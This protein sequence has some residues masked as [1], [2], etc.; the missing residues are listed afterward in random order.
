MRQRAV[1]GSLLIWGSA[2]RA[3]MPGKAP[4][5]RE[6]GQEVYARDCAA[7]HGTKALGDGPAAAVL[8]VPAPALAGRAPVTEEAAQIRSIL[9]GRGSMPGFSAIFDEADARKVLA[10]L[11]SLDPATGVDPDARPP[12]APA[13]APAATDPGP[14]TDGPSKAG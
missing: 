14:A 5:D 3:E 12:K 8:G 10:W 11:R 2:A 4:P 9:D 1:L 7:C 13:K 6:R